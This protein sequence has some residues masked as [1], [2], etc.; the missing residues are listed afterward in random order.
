MLGRSGCW[1]ASWTPWWC[2]SRGACSG[3][4]GGTASR[5]PPSSFALNLLNLL[6]LSLFLSLNTVG[7]LP[8]SLPHNP[9]C[10]AKLRCSGEISKISHCD[11]LCSVSSYNYHALQ[12]HG[13]I[14]CFPDQVAAYLVRGL[15]ISE[16][17]SPLFL[18]PCGFITIL[19]IWWGLSCFSV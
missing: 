12:Y 9:W 3:A 10:F 16:S 2:A 14:A 17:E 4:P 13:C 7:S 8:V 18:Y 19:A 11:M 5:H 6:S 1:R 15:F